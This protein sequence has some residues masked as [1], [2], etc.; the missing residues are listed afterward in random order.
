MKRLKSGLSTI[1]K[2]TKHVF[3]FLKS[4]PAVFTPFLIVA[5]LELFSL[6]IIYFSPR[7]PLRLVLGP[8]IRTFWG[9]AFLHYPLNFALFPKL[10]SLARM[11]ISIVAGSLIAGAAIYMVK[12]AYLTKGRIKTSIAFREALKVYFYFFFI[13]F[14]TTA[15]FYFLSKFSFIILAKYFLA[16]HSRLL[17]I[18][19]RLW[20][21][22]ILIIWN[23][24]LAILVQS[25]FVYAMPA[26]MIDK[27]KTASAIKQSFIIFKRHLPATLALVGIPTL[28]YLPIIILNANISV[29]IDKFFPESVVVVA[30]CGTLLSSLVIDPLIVCASSFVYLLHKD[31]VL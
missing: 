10:A 17:F 4:H 16:G 13:A 20:L 18:K 22:P 29:L 3:S 12:H 9:E 27:K 11:V 23:L 15:F 28:I 26:I 21:G 31:K 24:A 7:M 8:I 19:S 6:I 25:V 30:L 2:V 5:G 1:T 14:L